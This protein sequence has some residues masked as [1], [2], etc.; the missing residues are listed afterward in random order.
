MDGD[1]LGMS[2]CDI[3]DGFVDGIALGTLEGVADGC[4]TSIGPC[5]GTLVGLSDI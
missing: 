2:D 1:V 3:E 5:E 4:V